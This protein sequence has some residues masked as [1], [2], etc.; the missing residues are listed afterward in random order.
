METIPKYDYR[1]IAEFLITLDCPRSLTVYLLAKYG[2]WEQVVNLG[3]NP[4]DYNTL[5]SARSA[6]LAVDFLRKHENLPTKID[7]DQKAYNGF[8][9]A[10]ELCKETNLRLLSRNDYASVLFKAQRKIAAILGPLN[11]DAIIDLAGWGPGSTLKIKRRSASSANKFRSKIELTP[12]L[13]KVFQKPW[14]QAQFPHWVMNFREYEGNKVITVPK[15]AKT[16]RV[17]AV[18]PSGNLYLQKGVGSYIRDR[19][20]HF[21]VDLTDQ[22]TN[23]KFAWFASKG[24]DIATVDFSA[25]SDTISSQL[26]LDLLPFDWFQMLD[27][28]RSPR[29]YVK[30]NLIEYEK[31]SSMGNGFTFEL[32][33]LIFYALA[34]AYC[35]E[36]DPLSTCISVYGDDLVLPSKYITGFED[37]CLHVGF[38]INMSKSYWSGYYRESCGYHYWDGHDITPIY[39]R[40]NLSDQI[41]KMHLHNRLVELSMRTVGFGFRDKRFRNSIEFLRNGARVLVPYGYG[42]CGFITS[43]DEASPL[44]LDKNYM[45]GY[46]RYGLLVKP[47]WQEEDDCAFLCAKLYDLSKRGTP[48]NSTSNCS[49]ETFLDKSL[50]GQP[51]GNKVGY[52]PRRNY[53]RKRIWFPDWPCLG[54][55][56]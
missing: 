6:L 55:Y 1:V 51:T 31:F 17:I 37:L 29:G 23:Q 4:F 33:S 46:Q 19:L 52:S 18:E 3:F 11:V 27:L 24:N 49:V 5:E 42:D 45:R 22:S 47:F 9:E 25:A 32:E 56:L 34:C 35:D 43:F 40:R 54:S 21:G 48:S 30:D 20:L 41:E 16:N 14:F 15:N 2:E 8:F 53:I 12:A 13:L 44:V 50:D 36:D 10:E 39:L 7:L 28:L 26:V 38:K